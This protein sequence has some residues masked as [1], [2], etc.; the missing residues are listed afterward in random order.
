MEKDAR[1]RSLPNLTMTYHPPLRPARARRFS[2]LRNVQTSSGA[3]PASYSKVT[4]LLSRGKS[5]MDG[6]FATHLHLIPR[7]RIS[8]P[9]PPHP[10]YAFKERTGTT[11]FLPLPL[12]HYFVLY[13][14]D[15]I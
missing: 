4:G 7:L 2:L 15:E 1:I 10:L 5:G 8:G 9:I 6:K 14:A 13:S 11:L 3:H 12:R